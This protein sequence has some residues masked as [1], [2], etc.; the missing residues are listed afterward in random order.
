MEYEYLRNRKRV[1]CVYRVIMYA[2]NV[3]R[4]REQNTLFAFQHFSSAFLQYKRTRRVFQFFII[5]VGEIT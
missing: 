2:E 1:S 4:I 5:A 3:G